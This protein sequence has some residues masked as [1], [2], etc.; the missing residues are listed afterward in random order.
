[1]PCSKADQEAAQDGSQYDADLKGHSA[2]DNVLHKVNRLMTSS[3]LMKH[4]KMTSSP[5]A[6]CS[7]PT[8]PALNEGCQMFAR[9]GSLMKSDQAGQTST[10]P[11]AQG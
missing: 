11:L 3:I 7:Q 1:M 10:W 4:Y 6:L 8:A 5:T 2:H 9:P